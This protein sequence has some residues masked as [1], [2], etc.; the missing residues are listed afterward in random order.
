MFVETDALQI[1]LGNIV[2]RVSTAGSYL[3]DTAKTTQ[4]KDRYSSLAMAVRY[5]AELEERRKREIAGRNNHA[6][7]GLLTQVRRG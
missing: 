3:Y 1:E 2:T 6:C 7:I 5:V 4:R